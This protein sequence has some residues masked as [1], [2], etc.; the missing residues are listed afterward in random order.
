M[1]PL[2]GRGAEHQAGDGVADATPDRDVHVETPL[3]QHQ[4]GT[5]SARDVDCVADREDVLDGVLPVG[6]GGD[7]GPCGSD[8]VEVRERRTEGVALA[9]VEGQAQHLGPGGSGRAHVRTR[10]EVTAVVD[11]QDVER[12]PG[13]EQGLDETRKH[14]CR[15]EGRDDDE[16][17]SRR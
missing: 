8:L 13:L 15:L 16:H 12:W 1:E 11:D 9:P 17:L 4:V 2:P 14:H 10:R 5:R 6:V 3:T 7:D